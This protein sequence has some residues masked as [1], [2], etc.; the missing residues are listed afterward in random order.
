[1]R[2]NGDFEAGPCGLLASKTG[3]EFPYMIIFCSRKK[4]NLAVQFQTK[5]H[6]AFISLIDATKFFPVVSH[7]QTE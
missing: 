3:Y 2:C 1:M 4:C 5:I 7:L 6:D